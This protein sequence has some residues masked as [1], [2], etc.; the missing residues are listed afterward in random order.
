MYIKR[1][2]Q[3]NSLADIKFLNDDLMKLNSQF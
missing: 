3:I 1:I 2:I